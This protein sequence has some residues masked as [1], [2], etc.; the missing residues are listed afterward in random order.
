M[1][2]ILCFFFFLGGG[3]EYMIFHRLKRTMHIM[4]E[5]CSLGDLSL[6]C[7]VTFPNVSWSTSE[8]RGRLAS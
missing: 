7:F 8:L 2:A 4:S 1:N 5:A 6:L 3:S